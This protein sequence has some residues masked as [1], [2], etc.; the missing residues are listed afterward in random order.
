[1]ASDGSDG[2]PAPGR[3]E[4]KRRKRA[5]TYVDAAKKII[6]DEGFEALTMARLAEALDTAVSAVYRYFPSKGALMTSIQLEAVEQLAVSL[7][8][9]TDRADQAF[10]T[11]GLD[12]RD[13]AVARL[14]LF[15]RWLCAA[16]LVYPEDIRLLQMIMSQ[17]ASV[18]DEGGGERV[19][20]LAM[21]LVGQA[22]SALE[23]AS[24]AGV[25]S[26]GDPVDRA[27]IWASGLGGVLQTDD[28]EHYA[29][30]LFGQT[31]LALRTN[32]DLL[33]GWGVDPD[34][35]IRTD[36]VIDGIADEEPL[37]P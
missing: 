29:P 18:L 9:V 24:E 32:K 13:A 25:I 37:A 26:D 12:D 6:A 20:P 14:V 33:L 35:L 36:R 30:E 22:V 34:A 7:S 8:A 21:A 4:R 1:M 27:V 23:V 28:L 10:A 15:G 19:F 31:R 2:T 3:V 16:S 11:L 5:R 17:R